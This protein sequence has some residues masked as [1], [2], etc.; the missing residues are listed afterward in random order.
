MKSSGPRLA[1]RDDAARSEPRKRDMISL[2]DYSREEIESILDSAAEL[3]ADLRA[4][5]RSRPLIGKTMVMIFEKPSLRTRVTF[6]TGIKQLGGESIYL[7]PEDIRLGA[8]ETVADIARNLSRWV[9][10]IV[11][12]TFSHQ[13]LVELAR[14]A[15]I[16]VINGLTDLLHPCQVLADCL[17]LREHRGDLA[18]LTV[19]FV[20]DGNNVV[21]S[22]LNASA[23]LGMRFRLGCPP[24]YEPDATIL[25]H[26]KQIAGSRIEVLHDPVAAVTGADAVYTDVWTSMGQ[27]AESSVR[28]IAFAGYQVNGALVKH[29]KKDALVMHCLPAHRGEEITAEV[30]DGPRSVVLDQ[31]ENRLHVQ[32]ALMVWLSR[33]TTGPGVNH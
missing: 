20:G 14:H 6:E 1:A 19:A 11:A 27:E 12:R 22:W 15:T 33:A 7:A 10:L 28:R 31:A 29:A 17:T 13:A 2:A 3:K 4:G 23:A 9:E 25:A 16:P 21:N 32:K 24:G 30:L 26:A 18:K 8:R 5:G